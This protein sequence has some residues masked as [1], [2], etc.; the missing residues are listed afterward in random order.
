M[1]PD[2]D[3]YK[4]TCSCK[5][6]VYCAGIESATSCTFGEYSDH[7]AKLVVNYNATA[8]ILT[9]SQ[10]SNLLFT[11]IHTN[12]ALSPKGPRFTKIT[13]LWGTLQT[14]PINPS[15]FDCSLL[16]CKCYQSLLFTFYNSLKHHKYDAFSITVTLFKIM[17]M[18]NELFCSIL[19]RILFLYIHI[20]S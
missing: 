17:D 11:N 14:W 9:L 2:P 19:L 1:E 7:C 8:W 6:C 15:S 4:K 12:H 10:N 18:G 20:L 3:P 5:Q 13:Y 16:R